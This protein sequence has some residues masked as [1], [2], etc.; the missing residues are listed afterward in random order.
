MLISLGLLLLLGG[1]YYGAIAWQ[2]NQAANIPITPSPGF[3]RIGNLEASRLTRIETPIMILERT[4]DLWQVTS[5]NGGPPP[6]ED[7]QLDQRQ[8]MN[9]SFSLAGILIDSVIDEDPEDISIFGLDDPSAWAIVYDI[10]GNRAEY[11]RGDLTPS[12]TSFYAMEKGDPRVFTISTF[13]GDNFLFDL[14]RIRLRTYFPVMDFETTASFR[15][16]PPDERPIEIG[17]RTG[18]APLHLTTSFTSFFM[19]SPYALMRGVDSEAFNDNILGPLSMINMEGFVDDNPSSLVPYGLDRPTRL[20][21]QS[22]FGESLE[23]LVGNW[24]Q[25]THFAMLPG[26]NRV[27]AVSGLDSIMQ[28]RPFTLVEKFA[29]LVNIDYVERIN[30]TGERGLLTAEVQGQR[31]DAIFFLNGRRAEDR[32][33]R[34]WYQTVIGLLFDAEYP[35]PVQTQ[36][37]GEG[38]I[39]IE[40]ELNLFPG[41]RASIT[42]IPYNRDFYA[43][44]Q[45]GSIEF[46][47]SRNQVNNIWDTFNTMT[48]MD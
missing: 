3:Q 45:E 41:A 14:D 44:S 16:E 9:L 19:H 42:L 13:S 40:Y 35:G 4:D 28:I 37:T 11:I 31:D 15:L 23:L 29:L 1:G 30:I 33:F 17:L 34:Q 21:V 47:I 26:E 39:T 8:I 36:D 7:I 20:Q 25:G 22:T 2:R 32:P 10:D 6:S 48:Y 38:S 46:L 27:L 43:L 12:R 5:L 24:R 18:I